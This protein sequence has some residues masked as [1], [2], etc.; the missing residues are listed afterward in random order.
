MQW[1]EI[2]VLS[3]ILAL[4]A[5]LVAFSYG[6]VSKEIKINQGLKLS[7]VMGFFQFLMP[8]VGYFLFKS[9]SFAFGQY[10]QNIDHWIVF[11]I[12]TLLG[13]KIIKD[14]LNQEKEDFSLSLGALLL[15]GIAT[16]IDALAGG[17]MIYAQNLPILHS[18]AMIG[19]ITFAL[20]MAGYYLSKILNSL[21]EKILGIFGGSLLI[22]LGIKILIQHLLDSDSIL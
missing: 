12:F 21:P 8:L 14:S 9:T 7:F 16:S 11:V 20:V 22:L 18:T 10:A 1:F 6:L 17:I 4:D 19:I 5:F 15:L 13:G 2:F 3:C